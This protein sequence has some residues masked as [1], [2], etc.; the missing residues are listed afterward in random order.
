M[1][2]WVKYFESCQ[3]LAISFRTVWLAVGKQLILSFTEGGN[4]TACGSHWRIAGWIRQHRE[5]HPV[6]QITVA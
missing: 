5:H 2:Y 1:L 4:G 3:K 6:P